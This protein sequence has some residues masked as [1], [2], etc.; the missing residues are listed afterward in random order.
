MKAPSSFSVSKFETRSFQ[1]RVELA[2]AD[3]H[4]GAPPRL[5]HA[6]RREGVVPS[7]SE[8]GFKLKALWKGHPIKYQICLKPGGVLSSQGQA[9]TP[10]YRELEEAVSGDKVEL[11]HVGRG[12]AFPHVTRDNCPHLAVLGDVFD[13]TVI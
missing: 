11:E 3:P 5:D 9:C 13:H 8:T 10:P 4:P 6:R 7:T 12:L 1:S 2:P